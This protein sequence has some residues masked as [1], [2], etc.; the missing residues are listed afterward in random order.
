MNIPASPKAGAC[1]EMALRRFLTSSCTKG[2]HILLMRHGRRHFI[3]T[4]FLT[5]IT[6]QNYRG[7][8]YSFSVIH[9]H[10]LSGHGSETKR[11]D[12]GAPTDELINWNEMILFILY[13]SIRVLYRDGMLELPCNR[14]RLSD[15][16]PTAVGSILFFCCHWHQFSKMWGRNMGHES[17]NSGR[18]CVSYPRASCHIIIHQRIFHTVRSVNSCYN[19]TATLFSDTV[20]TSKSEKHEPTKQS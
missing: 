20:F 1:N 5:R 14:S 7:W 17:R 4:N 11:R 3:T 19:I 9:W 10:F 16:L 6:S 18:F 12:N 2:F 8:Q 15:S 13:S